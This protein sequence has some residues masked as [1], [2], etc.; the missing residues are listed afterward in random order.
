[1]IKNLYFHE[2]LITVNVFPF[3]LRQMFA[4]T[5]SLQRKVLEDTLAGHSDPATAIENTMGIKNMKITKNTIKHD[6]S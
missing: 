1:M 2:T 6:A 5:L 3:H 4:L